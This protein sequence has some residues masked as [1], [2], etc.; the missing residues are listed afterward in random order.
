MHSHLLRRTIVST[1][2]F[3][4]AALSS[5]G[6]LKLTGSLTGDQEVPPT[7]STAVGEAALVLDPATGD[8]TLSISVTGLAN[9]ITMA[10]LHQAAVGVNGP[11]IAPLD[12]AEF[13]G[14]ANLTTAQFNGTLTADQIGPVLAGETYVNI[15][16][17]VEAGGEIRG[18]LILDAS[19]PG[20]LAALSCRGF[21]NPGNGKSGILIG[22][23]IITDPGQRVIVRVVGDGLQRW[24]TANEH[25]LKD[26][27]LTVFDFDGNKIGSNDNWKDDGQEFVVLTTGLAPVEESDAAL[28]LDLPPGG[29][30]VHADS[31]QGAGL[32]LMEMFEVG[33]RPVGETIARAAKSEFTI[34]YQALV[35]AGLVEILNGPGP[36]T[37]FAPTDAALADVVLPTD[38]DELKA[39]LLNHIV[40]AN[41]PSDALTTGDL[42]TAGG[43]TLSV[44]VSADPITVDGANVIGPDIPVTNGVI[45]VIDAPLVP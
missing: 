35:D 13:S 5:Y 18:Q 28:V 7:T 26:T 9:T 45:H 11:A 36:Y 32:A 30:T 21:I 15:H 33:I 37:L 17:D 39:F 27:S 42:T 23:F 19:K 16:T 38:P 44:D 3:A 22:G 31:E 4:L 12:I 41:L 43:G 2:T 14:D 29:Y 40:T 8:Y 24:L 25:S 6:Q 34:L 1:L 20:S 10:H